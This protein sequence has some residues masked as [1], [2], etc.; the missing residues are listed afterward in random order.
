MSTALYLCLISCWLLILFIVLRRFKDRALWYP[1]TAGV[2]AVVCFAGAMSLA[3]CGCDAIRLMCYGFLV[4]GLI[5]LLMC[6]CFARSRFKVLAGFLVFCILAL[7]AGTSDAFLIEPH[8]LEVRHFEMSSSKLRKP[9]R[10]ALASDFHVTTVG[11]YETGVIKAIMAEKPDLILLAGDYLAPYEAKAIWRESKAFHT[12]LQ[13]EGVTARLGVFAVEGDV[14]YG[15]RDWPEMFAG[16]GIKTFRKRDTV[17]LDEQT[18]LTGF[19]VRESGQQATVKPDAKFHIV[20]VHHPDLVLC[21]TVSAD[22]L[23]AGHCHGGQVQVPLIGPLITLSKIPRKWA[24]GGLFEVRRG[25]F[26]AET[27]G[28]GLEH[29]GNPP[30]LRFLCRPD[31]CI[32]DVKPGG[33]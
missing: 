32:I 28:V 13:N 14:E 26:L 4:G 24:G 33:K 30:E 18:E 12:L 31:I 29:A 10:I 1:L 6:F 23:V 27:R 25:T 15:F 19:N 8:W 16:L 7:V 11:G 17:E 5:F 21:N 20:L 22:L 3:Y 2:Y 9:L